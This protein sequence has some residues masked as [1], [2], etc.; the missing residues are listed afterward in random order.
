MIYLMN[1][2][3]LITK[4]IIVPN[5]I[6]VVEEC[7]K[8][9]GEQYKISRIFAESA[10]QSKVMQLRN[11]VNL[12]FNEVELKLYS[13]IIKTNLDYETKLKIISQLF[14]LN[15]IYNFS[16][17]LSNVILECIDEYSVSKLKYINKL[18]EE[19]HLESE[20]TKLLNNIPEYENNSKVL[21]IV[22]K[23]K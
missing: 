23:L 9:K 17:I 21:K 2:E 12:K 13:D 22:K 15:D 16:V 1:D 8:K 7:A 6:N 20:T 14:E 19:E 4:H 10:L 3:R 18:C 11:E 5:N